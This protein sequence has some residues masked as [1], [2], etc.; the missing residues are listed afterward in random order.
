M[1]CSSSLYGKEKKQ[2]VEKDI[3]VPNIDNTTKAVATLI[4]N[5]LYIDNIKFEYKN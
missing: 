1:F 4:G 2:D 5:A 3:N